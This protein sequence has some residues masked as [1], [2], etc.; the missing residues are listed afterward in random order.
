LYGTAEGLLAAALAATLL[1]HIAV[2]QEA[3]PYALLILLA[4]LTMRA[5]YEVMVSIRDDRRLSSDWFATVVASSAACC[6]THYFGLLLVALQAVACAALAA[7]HRRRWVTVIG[8]YGTVGV[9]CAPWVPFFLIQLR[10]GTSWIPPLEAAHLLELPSFFFNRSDLTVWAV[11]LIIAAAVTKALVTRG[12]SPDSGAGHSGFADLST[13]WW[14]A[15]PIVAAVLVSW[16]VAPVV[17]HK[18]LLI[19]LPPCVI[20]VA[21]CVWILSPPRWLPPALGVALV[22]GSLT[23]LI[24]VDHYY[25][26]PTNTQ[27]R[28]AAHHMVAR[29]AMAG[30]LPIAACTWSGR[31][32]DYYFRD[33]E[34]D[35]RVEWVGCE[36]P[37]LASLLTPAEPGSPDRLWFVAVHRAEGPG[38][39]EWFREH[40]FLLESKRFIEAYV[41]LLE[42]RPVA[43]SG[44]KV[45]GSVPQR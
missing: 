6:Y 32:L 9:L 15:A 21:R 17:T 26:T 2:S 42:R 37:L 38:V 27:F 20:L 41:L 28:E 39:L 19:C 23:H 11:V 18:N 34:S 31:Y 1:A 36:Q 14:L 29:S 8:V 22:A 43:G 13:V 44:L 45:E 33:L 7:A 24:V 3:R 35:L 4:T 12:K 40:Y 16:L 10:R 30:D 5:S 25:T